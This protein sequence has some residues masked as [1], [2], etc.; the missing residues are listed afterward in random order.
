LT[1]HGAATESFDDSA[2]EFPV[3]VVETVLV[4]VEEA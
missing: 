2:Q 4:N 3:D 1:A